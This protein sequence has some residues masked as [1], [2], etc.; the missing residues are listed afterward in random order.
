MQPTAYFQSINANIFLETSIPK[1][2]AAF[3]GNARIKAGRMP[4]NSALGPSSLIKCLY[5]SKIP[6]Y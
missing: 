4:L 1:K 3:A 5:T 2:Q 6:L